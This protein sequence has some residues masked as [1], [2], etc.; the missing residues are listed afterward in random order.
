MEIATYVILTEEQQ[1]QFQYSALKHNT[2]VEPQLK[3][4]CLDPLN[5]TKPW[6]FTGIW[7]YDPDFSKGFKG[8]KKQWI[9]W[10]F[11]FPVI[12]M[13]FRNS[14]WNNLL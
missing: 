12:D 9:I 3:Q 11:G 6:E 14:F 1:C 4:T 8:K 10:S 2:G 7:R 13:K 5:P